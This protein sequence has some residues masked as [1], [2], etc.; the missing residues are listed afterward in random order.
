MAMI[1]HSDWLTAEEA[2]QYLKVKPRTLLLATIPIAV[3]ARFERNPM[4]R[5]RHKKGS[6]VFDRR[7]KVWNY[8][9]CDDGVRR[10]KPI[11]TIRDYPTKAAAWRAVDLLCLAPVTTPATTVPTVKVVAER[12]EA[13][14]LPTRSETARVYK[15]WL[16]NH[17]L[18]KW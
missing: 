16:H 11:G 15:S 7:R 1:A 18:P 12:Y 13:E 5:V 6:V 10:T 17:I 2:A 8:L 9:Y 3:C 4:R 14:K